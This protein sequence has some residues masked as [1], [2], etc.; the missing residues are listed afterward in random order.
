METQDDRIPCEICGA[1]VLR[2]TAERYGGLC[3]PC[4]DKIPSG[5]EY[6]FIEMHSVEECDLTLKE[7]A[8][9]GWTVVSHSSYQLPGTDP[10]HTFTFTRIAKWR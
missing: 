1:G 3:K 5:P 4:Y 10:V 9:A 7:W 2:V 8:R 6:R